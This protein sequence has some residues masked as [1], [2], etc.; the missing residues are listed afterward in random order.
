MN[1]KVCTHALRYWIAVMSVALGVVHCALADDKVGRIGVVLA[2]SPELELRGYDGFWRRLQA[3][4]WVRGK[5]LIVEERSAHGDPRLLPR[6]MREVLERNVDVI[7]TG[8]TPSGFAAKNATKTVPIV[9]FSVGDP[10]GSGLVSSLAHPGGNIT[11]FSTQATDGL[12]GKWLELMH[13]AI[14]KL[15]SVAVIFNPANPLNELQ[16]KQLQRDAPAVHIAL[17]TIAVTKPEALEPALKRAGTMARAA[18]VLTDPL[19][20]GHRKE[21]IAAA[22]RY[23]VPAMYT[24]LEFADAGGLMAHGVD[25]APQMRRSAEY[26]DKILRGASAGDLPIEQPGQ[27]KVVFNMRAAQ[28]LG[29]AIPES[30]LMRADEVIK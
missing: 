4:G 11:G 2:Q 21:V 19:T 17:S 12:P 5:N 22:A 20:I 30:V 10:V 18:L 27:F 1:G 26:V 6:L 7:L 13:E 8:S 23:R 15:S 14:P 25:H 24:M 16:L 28:T 3:L 29:I 9:L